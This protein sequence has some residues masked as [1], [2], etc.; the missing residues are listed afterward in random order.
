MQQNLIS[1]KVSSLF[2]IIK[3][4]IIKGS[5]PLHLEEESY[6]ASSMIPDG[7]HKVSKD[8]FFFKTG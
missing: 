7:V 1:L 4:C 6:I 2:N 5:Y 8:R 3:G